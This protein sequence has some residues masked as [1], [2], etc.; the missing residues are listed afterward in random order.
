MRSQ[1]LG[2]FTLTVLVGVLE[3][4]SL[5][6]PEEPEGASLNFRFLAR[7]FRISDVNGQFEILP[8][9]SES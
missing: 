5:S 4:N 6:S 3:F 2:L 1:Y 8:S 9:Q 7:S